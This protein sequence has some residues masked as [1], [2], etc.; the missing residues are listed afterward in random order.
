MHNVQ[1]WFNKLVSG[2]DYEEVKGD[3]DVDEDDFGLTEQ[4]DDDNDKMEKLE[5]NDP[6]EKKESLVD[7]FAESN[8]PKRLVMHGPYIDTSFL[9]NA[10]SF[11]IYR[12]LGGW[13]PHTEHVNI[14]L[15]HDATM[16][17]YVLMEKVNEESLGI[18]RATRRCL[19][20][21]KKCKHFEALIKFDW[22]VDD[23]KRFSFPM[24]ASNSSVVVQYPKVP[25]YLANKYVPLESSFANQTQIAMDKVD[26]V[27]TAGDEG[28]LGDVL[29][30]G[31]FVRFF[32]LEEIAKDLDG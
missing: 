27:V 24:D 20:K 22:A 28:K 8:H 18:R 31:S 13:A 32:L 14:N 16:G 25:N 17:L 9:R 10:L 2:A 12:Q 1:N 6:E 3:D 19:R 5:K 4:A 11:H 15:N 23:G 30:V 7:V 29:D 21:S 26:R